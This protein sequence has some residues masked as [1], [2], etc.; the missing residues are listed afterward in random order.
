[1]DFLCNFACYFSA[2]RLTASLHWYVYHSI[3]CAD[4][5]WKHLSFAVVKLGNAGFDNLHLHLVSS[6]YF[7]DLK[8][9]NNL[10]VAG[11]EV[12]LSFF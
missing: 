11:Q 9:P 7:L 6:H 2:L 4:N 10:T 5:Y 8:S 1:L 12:K 3:A